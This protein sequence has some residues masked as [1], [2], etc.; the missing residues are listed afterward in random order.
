MCFLGVTMMY[1][2][3][4]L[5]KSHG[6]EAL[7]TSKT[8]GVYEFTLPSGVTADDVAKNSKYYELYMTPTF[9]AN[10][11]EVK[12]ELKENADKN[13]YIIARFLTVCGVQE[14]AVDGKNYTMSQF[15]DTYLK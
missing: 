15:I 4:N 8:N 10:S 11:H 12:I 5:A 7:R 13:R 14:I 6:A 3:D 9:D 1:A 2:Q